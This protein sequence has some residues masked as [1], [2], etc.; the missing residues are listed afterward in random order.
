MSGIYAGG[1]DML[2]R[3]TRYILADPNADVPV[4]VGVRWMQEKYSLGTIKGE[5][6]GMAAVELKGDGRTYL[7][8]A[9][10]KG[11]RIYRPD[12][13]GE[14]LDV[15]DAMALD[16][17]SRQ[18]VWMDINGDGQV[19]LVCWDGAAITIQMMVEEEKLV[20]LK[21]NFKFVSEC[22]GLAAC[23]LNAGGTPAI[24]L[25]K[26][27]LPFILTWNGDDGWKK[28]IL[29]AGKISQEIGGPVSVCIVAD[30]NND[31]FWDILQ[32]RRTAG[33]LW[34]GNADGF[35]P[36][37]MSKVSDPDGKCSLRSPTTSSY[38]RFALGDFDQDGYLDIFIS[39]ARRNELGIEP[40]IHSD[41]P[42]LTRG[43]LEW[44]Q[45]NYIRA[46]NLTRANA[47]L[48]ESQTHIPLAQTWGGG[49]VIG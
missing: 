8:V 44:V 2:R 32:P 46:E 19:E 13:S 42:A 25:S 27:G 21:P 5:I 20:A 37:I 24:V 39:G 18:F 7:Y 33:L 29:P 30:L 10:S 14:F 31:G 41:N 45:Q 40:L 26:N 22:L 17:Q 9:A 34:I 35:S 15:T 16:S 47:R 1:T 28:T 23:S 3:M 48:V 38:G 4:S 36:P 6:A 43:R 49:E 11:D 12:E